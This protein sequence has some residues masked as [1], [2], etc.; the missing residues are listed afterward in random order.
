[1][2]VYGM[3]FKSWATEA[4][5]PKCLTMKADV[6][7]V[8]GHSCSAL[9][10]VPGWMSALLLADQVSAAMLGHHCSPGDEQLTSYAVLT[11]DTIWVNEAISDAQGKSL[12]SQA[13]V[14]L[15]STGYCAISH[16]TLLVPWM[17]M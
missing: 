8:R 13:T 9:T 11:R 12:C 17:Q 16:R 3:S 15:L 5:P 14:R 7:R 10:Q 6:L 1:M 4:K 2:C